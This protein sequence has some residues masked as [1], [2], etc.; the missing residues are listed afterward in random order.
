MD[1][2]V[3]RWVRRSSLLGLVIDAYKNGRLEEEMPIIFIM[4]ND[5]EREYNNNVERMLREETV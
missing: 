4:E 2:G 1:A 5:I 3:M